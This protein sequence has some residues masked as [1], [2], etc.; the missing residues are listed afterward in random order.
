MSSAETQSFGD[1]FTTAIVRMIEV[2][3]LIANAVAFTIELQILS[4]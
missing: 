3:H 4:S 1:L 2:T